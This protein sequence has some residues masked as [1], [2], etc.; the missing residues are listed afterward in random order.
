M[1]SF[2]RACVWSSLNINGVGAEVAWI[3]FPGVNRLCLFFSVGLLF[4]QS[5]GSACRWRRVV[6]LYI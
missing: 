2:A 6:L 1:E 5:A 4:F 3:R